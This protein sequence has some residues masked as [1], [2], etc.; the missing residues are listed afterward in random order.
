MSLEQE[1]SP[2]ESQVNQKPA[3]RGWTARDTLILTALIAL[4]MV[5][6][7]PGLKSFGILD[8]SDGL[9]AECSREMLERHD[10]LTPSFNYQPFYEKPILIYW[11]IM[12]AYKIFCVSE[13]AA[14]LPSALSGVLCVAA[15]YSLSRQFINRR[16]ALLSSLVLLASPLFA[17]V[18]HL[19]LTDMLLTLFMTCATL[20][21]FGR[22]FGGS[23]WLL[24][25]A[26][27]SLGLAMLAKGP[28]ALFLV[29]GTLVLYLICRGRDPAEKWHQFW[30]RRLWPLHPIAGLA[31]IL[32]ISAPWYIAEHTATHG[33]FF[34]EF[35]IRQNLGRAAGTVNHQNPWY[36]YIPFLLGGLF[37][38]WLSLA[39]M[40]EPVARLWRHRKFPG[41][42]P[43]L[44]L[45]CLCWS[46]LIIGLFS[47]V[48]TKLG[49]Y[50]LPAFPPLALLTGMVLD[51]GLRLRAMRE[52]LFALS[53]VLTVVA[54]A[55][56]I[57]LPIVFGKLKVVSLGTECA[58]YLG[59][60]L[61]IG[62]FS[63][64]AYFIRANRAARGVC[65]ATVCSAMSMALL[66]PAGLHQYDKMQHLPFRQ[67]LQICKDD[68][69]NVAT[70]LR[71]SPAAN[72]YLARK[73]PLLSSATEVQQ[74]IKDKP[75]KHYL[76]LTKDVLLQA[77][78][79]VPH[80]NLVANK[81]K[82]YLYSI[83]Q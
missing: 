33:E 80:L 24:A 9:Y 45:L 75:G 11:T 18:G 37:P 23:I 79:R 1:S 69:A 48:R 28:V 51:Q 52:R 4:A 74:F 27:V 31:L 61:M 50:I 36:Y 81:S 19:C 7:L 34:Q 30:W 12:I 70:F 39:V 10:L 44:G 68:S 32:A 58:F 46:V 63:I 54:V 78:Q 62:G 73:V 53:I 64:C 40:V 77:Q 26:Y 47:A 29:G 38:W 25:L 41:R 13:W 71:D 2:V 67:L 49:T 43:Q 42:S 66:I 5:I 35:F 22:L 83:D 82:W 21:L 57:V 14:R 16:A 8:P 59:A 6:F 15:L 76:L 60:A 65:C 20:S 72:F 55:A 17:V 3:P 56:G